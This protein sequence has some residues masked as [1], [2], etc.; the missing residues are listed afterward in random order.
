MNHLIKT[1]A[2]GDSSVCSC[3]NKEKFVQQEGQS[4]IIS[5]SVK[6]TTGTL[7][8]TLSTHVL[9]TA[10]GVPASNLQIELARIKPKA[11]YLGKFITGLDGRVHEV[12]LSPEEGILGIYEITFHAGDYL[13]FNGFVL[14]DYPF[15]DVIPIRFGIYDKT[16]YH[17]PLLLSPYGFSTYRGS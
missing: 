11:K 5:D 14:P 4:N 10:R 13:K 7:M 8:I 16:H 1:L 2:A 17:V 9:N 6:S 3:T 12:L 15:I